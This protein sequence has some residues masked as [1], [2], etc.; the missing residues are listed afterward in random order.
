MSVL[1]EIRLVCADDNCFE[2]IPAGVV[3][4]TPLRRVDVHQA[5][6]FA[7]GGGWR[8]RRRGLRVVADFCPAHA[9]QAGGR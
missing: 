5:R 4:D 8:V 1:Y 7:R 6:R 9:G 3:F 2:E